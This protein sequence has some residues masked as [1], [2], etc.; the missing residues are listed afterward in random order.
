MRHRGA[1]IIFIVFLLLGTVGYKAYGDELAISEERIYVE[2]LPDGTIKVK[3]NIVFDFSGSFNGVYKEVSYDKA[4]GI[5]ITRV[6]EALVPQKVNSDYDRYTLVEEAENGDERVYTLSN[7]DKKTRVKIFSP[8]EDTIKGFRISYNLYG[9]IEK[10]NDTAEFHWK[11]IGDENE[12]DINRL[13]IY[14]TFPEGITPEDMKVYGHGPLNGTVKI[15]NDDTALFVVPKLESGNYVEIRALFPG[16]LLTALDITSPENKLQ[17]ILEEERG[18]AEEQNKKL[19]VKETLGKV[20]ETAPIVMTSLLALLGGISI[21]MIKRKDYNP[22]EKEAYNIDD[23]DPILLSYYAKPY[24]YVNNTNGFIAQLL[25]LVRK[26]VL[27]MEY[28]EEQEDYLIRILPYQGE[29]MLHE[30]RLVDFLS[31]A[32]ANKEELYLST[33]KEYLSKNPESYTILSD[34]YVDINKEILGLGYSDRG[35]AWKKALVIISAVILFV[36]SI[37]ILANEVWLASISLVGAIGVFILGLLI[38][39]KS[40]EGEKAYETYERVKKDII[41]YKAL[42]VAELLKNPAAIEK[43]MIYGALFNYNEELTEKITGEIEEDY[44]TSI[45]SNYLLWNIYFTGHFQG[46]NVQNDIKDSIPSPPEASSDGGSG[47]G[48]TSGGGGFSSGGGGGAGG[49]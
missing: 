40:S 20:M 12:T 34:L 33:L 26:K 9:A 23:Y 11:F 27:S 28:I 31:E 42:T 21:F 3:D 32:A 4:S 14:L 22:Y 1:V 35:R 46:V 29:L 18:Y 39:T 49:F 6:E 10:Y 24:E 37:I 13:E 38:S 47:G 44:D 25:N 48:F 36:I 41:N 19:K 45:F 7:E 2:I 15:L 5:D 30:K 17:S 16:E 8:S 43:L